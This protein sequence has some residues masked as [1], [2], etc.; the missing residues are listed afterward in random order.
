MK[1]DV[2][3][4]VRQR[5]TLDRFLA[6]LHVFKEILGVCQPFAPYLDF[7]H[8]FGLRE[9]DDEKVRSGCRWRRNVA[10]KQEGLFDRCLYAV[11][12]SRLTRRGRNVLQH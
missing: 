11:Q 9:N 12:D 7:I 2:E 6:T 1:T 10:M 3:S 5:N 8:A 4:I